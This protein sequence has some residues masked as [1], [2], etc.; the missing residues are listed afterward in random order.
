MA[1]IFCGGTL[2]SRASYGKILPTY[3]KDFDEIYFA[4]D[5]LYFGGLSM[6]VVSR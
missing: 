4:E 5:F 1:S 3:W 2:G 6:K